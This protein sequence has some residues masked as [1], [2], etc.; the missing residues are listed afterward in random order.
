MVSYGTSCALPLF[1]GVY[2]EVNN[3]AIRGFI[4]STAGV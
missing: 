4:S 2:S 1:P 3:S